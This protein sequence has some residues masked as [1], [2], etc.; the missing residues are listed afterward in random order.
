[1]Q[2]VREAALA[3]GRYRLL[4]ARGVG[5]MATVWRAIDGR[6]ERPVAVKVMSDSLAVDEDYVV[7]F[8][9]E[10]RIAA[11]LSHPNLVRIF[12]FGTEDDRP[13]L[14]SEWIDGPDLLEL[15]REGARVDAE[16]LLWNLLE[17]LEHI[18]GEGILHRDVKPSNVLID[19]HG[20]ARL[21]DFG[22]AQPEDATRLTQTGLVMGTAPFIAPEVLAGE[23]STRRSDLYAVGMVIRYVTGVEMPPPLAEVV[24]RLTADDP[25]ARPPSATAA[26]ELAPD[27]FGSKPPG[28]PPT[29]VLPGPVPPDRDARSLLPFGV[30]LG[31][32]AVLSIVL[33][34]LA[35]GPK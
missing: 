13:F 28:A 14:V 12:D 2:L 6:L 18:H 8:H 15:H 20:E 3:A 16:R 9:R 30:G 25:E 27:P 21:T 33:A 29:A 1:M 10:A 34:L 7:R 24:S 5:G 4:E 35:N 11:G 32:I 22:I 31:A 26:L 23:P 17:A 19:G